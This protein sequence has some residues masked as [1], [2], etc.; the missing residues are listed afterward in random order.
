MKLDMVLILAI[1]PGW[2]GQKFIPFSTKRFERLQEMIAASGR[3]ILTAI[4]GGI[5]RENIQEVGR[6]GCRSCDQR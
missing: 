5:T 6:M 4:D 2:G 1:N 3:M